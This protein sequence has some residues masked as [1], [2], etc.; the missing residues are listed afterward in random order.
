M[1]EMTTKDLNLVNKTAGFERI[2]SHFERDKMLLNSTVCYIEI[3]HEM[4]SQLI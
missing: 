2:D 1:V 4:K 3:A